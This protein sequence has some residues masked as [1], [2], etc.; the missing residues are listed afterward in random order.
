[1]RGITSEG[2]TGDKNTTTRIV[3]VKS[4]YVF[5]RLRSLKKEKIGAVERRSDR[6]E[7]QKATIFPE[8]AAPGRSDANAKFPAALP[9][10]GTLR[11]RTVN[12]LVLQISL[13][14]GVFPEPEARTHSS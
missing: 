1:M 7:P 10:Y 9:H 11:K 8:E 4:G 13:Q 2:K 6:I 14:D 12:P 5:T 3:G